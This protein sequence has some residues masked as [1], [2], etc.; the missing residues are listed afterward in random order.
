MMRGVGIL[1]PPRRSKAHWRSETP[2]KSG[3]SRQC[4]HKLE[5]IIM[6]RSAGWRGFPTRGRRTAG[7]GGPSMRCQR[8]WPTS[9]LK[10]GRQRDFNRLSDQ[11]KDPL[12]IETKS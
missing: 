2:H 7:C 5:D 12:A 6:F 9:P 8:Q 3:W 1:A 10:A 4:R 11:H